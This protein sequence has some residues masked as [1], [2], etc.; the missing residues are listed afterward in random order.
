MRRR[1]SVL[2]YI[3]ILAAFATIA[4]VACDR[5]ITGN[6]DERESFEPQAAVSASASSPHFRHMRTS[7]LDYRIHYLKEPQKSAEYNWAAARYD[8]VTGGLGLLNA[9]KSRNPTIR[10]YMYDKLWFTPVADAGAAESWLSSRGYNV[11]NAYLHKAGTSKTKAN[12][13]TAQQYAGRDYWYYNLSNPGYLAYRAWRAQQSMKTN[14]AGYRSDSFFFDSNSNNAM[15]RYIPTTTLEFATRSAYMAAYHS[16]LKSQRNAVPAKH[17]II[18]QAQYF[19]KPDEMVSAGIAGGVMTEFSNS[20]YG[21]PR[22]AEI[23]HLVGQGVVVHLSTGV[24]PGSKNNQRADMNPGNYSSIAER[25]L[26]WEYGSY[27]M[28]AQPGKMDAVY[29]E[30]YGLNWSKPFTVAWLPA[31]EVDIGLAVAPRSVLKSGTDGAGQT[32]QI[33]QRQFSN[34]ALVVIRGQKGGTYGEATAVTVTLPGGSWRMV[35]PNGSLSSARTT[36]KVRNSEALL[37]IK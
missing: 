16:V 31:Y 2:P 22:W 5:E 12:R 10:H 14:A 37:F 8:K 9:Y 18:N 4:T 6:A 29:F 32:Y 7:V 23:D 1:G 33:L 15:N 17:V 13:I 26:M 30:P 3:R 27:L 11:E 35:W 28:V 21:R 25:V 20:P 36:V 24:S 34:N 19:T